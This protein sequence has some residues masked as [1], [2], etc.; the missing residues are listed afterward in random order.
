M[1]I[2]ISNIYCKHLLKFTPKYNFQNETILSPPHIILNVTDA[3][4][5]NAIKNNDFSDYERLLNTTYQPEH[6]LDIFK[7]CSF[8][9]RY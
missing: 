5:Y 8:L 6:S 3:I 4:H 1:S 2:D 9:I 7:N